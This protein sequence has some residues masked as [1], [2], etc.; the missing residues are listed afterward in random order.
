[1]NSLLLIVQT[2]T[3]Q[4]AVDTAKAPYSATSLDKLP[5]QV[6][7]S[8]RSGR[9]LPDSGCKSDDSSVSSTESATVM[10]PLPREHLARMREYANLPPNPLLK[11]RPSE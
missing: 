1:M 5:K 9:I 10:F 7:L 4:S 2:F 6:L 8:Q 11:W 3:V